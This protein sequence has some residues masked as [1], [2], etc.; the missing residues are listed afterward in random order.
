M[1]FLLPNSYEAKL[2]LIEEAEKSGMPHL[3]VSNFLFVDES[4]NPVTFKPC[5]FWKNLVE[6]EKV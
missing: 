5:N 1:K 4:K 2:A 6:I 3:G